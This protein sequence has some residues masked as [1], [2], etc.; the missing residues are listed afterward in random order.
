MALD[1]MDRSSRFVMAREALD[2]DG[3]DEAQD[4]IDRAERQADV[5][6]QFSSRWIADLLSWIGETQGEAAGEAA[7]RRLGQRNLADRAEPENDWRSVPAEVRANVVARAMPANGAEIELDED[8][9]KIAMSFRSFRCGTGGMLI[10][11]GS[12]EGEAALLQLTES[13]PRTFGRDS[14]WVS[15]VQA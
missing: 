5:L 9:E 3:A 6:K 8:D 1:G 15:W 14:L 2:D 4:Q 7:L 10:D 13:G 12:Y 11:S